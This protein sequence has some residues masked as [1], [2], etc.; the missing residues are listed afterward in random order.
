[1]NLGVRLVSFRPAVHRYLGIGII[2]PFLAIGCRKPAEPAAT[3]PSGPPVL[4]QVED[5]VI[6]VAQFE[7]EL[8][9]RSQRGGGRVPTPQ[10][11]EALLDEMVRFEVSFAHAKAAGLDRDPEMIQR[12][13]RMVVARYEE[14]HHADQEKTPAPTAAEVESY[15]RDHPAEF[16]QP[17]KVR[18]ALLF[19][20]VSPKAIEEKK[21]GALRRAESIRAEAVQQ[22]SAQPSF[23][24]L[25]RQHSE[26]AATRYRGGDS[27]WITKG[28]KNYAWPQEV[29]AAMFALKTTG[30]ISPVVRTSDGLYLVKLMERTEAAAAPLDQVRERI[31]WRLHQDRI[32]RGQKDFYERQKAGLRVAVNRD[33]LE[34]VKLPTPPDSATAA[35]PP[36]ALPSP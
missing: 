19:L 1:M 7:A 22:A 9:R 4:A 35:A 30:E 10:D 21:Q 20:K 15:Y 5:S 8:A 29:V 33:L 32:Q 14:Q 6:T 24:D 26:D 12:F 13:R 36:P 3:A 31:A 17:E 18:G 23:G 34:T 2:L 28:Q 25:A 11:R 16:S 27:G